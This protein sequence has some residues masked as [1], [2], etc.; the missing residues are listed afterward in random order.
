MREKKER[1][2]KMA[3]GAI[4]VLQE[5]YSKG[6]IEQF[7]TACEK[8]DCNAA[9]AVITLKYLLIQNLAFEQSCPDFPDLAEMYAGRMGLDMQE[10]TQNFYIPRRDKP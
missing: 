6:I 8:F 9:D 5:F 2:D 7:C 10:F 3:Q 4:A 1:S